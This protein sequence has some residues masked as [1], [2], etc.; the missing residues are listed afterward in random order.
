MLPIC[1]ESVR[2]SASTSSQIAYQ[3]RIC[4]AKLSFVLGGLHHKAENVALRLNA[5][6]ELLSPGL[7]HLLHEVLNDLRRLLEVLEP[8]SKELVEL[9]GGDGS[10]AHFLTGRRYAQ[11]GKTSRRTMLC[12]MMWRASPKDISPG[13][14]PLKSHGTG[15]PNP[16]DETT[17]RANCR[18]NRQWCSRDTP[19]REGRDLVCERVGAGDVDS[20]FGCPALFG[21]HFV[22]HASDVIP[23]ANVSVSRLSMTTYLLIRGGTYVAWSKA[24]V[25]M[26]RNRFQSSPFAAKRLGPHA[27]V[28]VHCQES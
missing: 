21:D 17:M 27:L 28:R 26:R 6:G 10:G 14:F 22:I 15:W 7:D 19:V 16:L 2:A 18:C 4:H 1:S 3:L 12:V 8:R 20:R 25:R 5:R 24:G 9:R 23:D 11:D 13:A